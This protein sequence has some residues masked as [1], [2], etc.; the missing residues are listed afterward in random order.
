[1]MACRSSVDAALESL[2]FQFR[3]GLS[4]TIRAVGKHVARRVGWIQKTVEFSTVVHAC[5]GHTV[6]SDQ[7]VLGVHVD[8]V[9]IAVVAPAALLRPTRVA[10]FLRHLLWL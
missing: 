4:R 7:L 8:V 1:M 6:A 2:G 9:F 3:L 5:V 10:V